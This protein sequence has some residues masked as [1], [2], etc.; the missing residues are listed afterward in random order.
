MHV[1]KYKQITIVN[2]NLYITIIIIIHYNE[3]QFRNQQHNTL[4]GKYTDMEIKYE[5]IIYHKRLYIYIYIYIYIFIWVI[6]ITNIR[7]YFEAL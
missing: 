5:V 6:I 7:Y 3:I 4:L 2:N 1:L